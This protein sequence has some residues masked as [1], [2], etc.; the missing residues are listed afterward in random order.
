[1][2]SIKVNMELTNR[3]E[4]NMDSKE[5]KTLTRIAGNDL[6]RQVFNDEVKQKWRFKEKHII[7]FPER[8]KYVAISFIQGFAN[9]ALQYEMSNDKNETKDSVEDR[10][11]FEAQSEKLKEQLYDNM[12][13]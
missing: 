13:Y 7:K 10:I 12:R 1:M 2:D 11:F 4:L 9:E 3:I 8:I 6:G 5:L